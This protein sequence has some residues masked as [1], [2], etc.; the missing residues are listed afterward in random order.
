MVLQTRA[1]DWHGIHYRFE[2]MEP[3]AP[4]EHSEIE[5]AVSRCGEFIGIMRSPP[6]QSWLDFELGA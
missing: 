3:I 1:L 5:W 2:R 4:Q 6:G